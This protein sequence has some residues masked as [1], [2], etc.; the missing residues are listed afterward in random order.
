MTGS[1]EESHYEVVR[2]EYE[3]DQ[4]CLS[5]F[6]EDSA[7]PTTIAVVSKPSR[8]IDTF[9]DEWMPAL[10]MPEK[11]LKRYHQYL[12]GYRANSAVDNPQRRAWVDAELEKEYLRYVR[13]SDE[14]QDAL[15]GIVSRLK[16]GEDITLVCY[17]KGSEPCHRHLLIE[18]IEARLSSKFF[19]QKRDSTLT[20]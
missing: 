19:S 5:D 17:E 9:C 12:A 8:D 20:A 18:L 3:S 7:S 1:L 14:A 10:G 16:G 15:A 6:S 4:R 11:Y 2:A 13:T